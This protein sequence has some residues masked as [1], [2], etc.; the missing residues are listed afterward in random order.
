MELRASPLRDPCQPHD[1]ASSSEVLLPPATS[2]SPLPSMRFRVPDERLH[3]P[4]TV[5][6]TI[7]TPY[8]PE[9]DR[10]ERPSRC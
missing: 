9:G 10:V 6:V 4:R 2:A 3:L 8:G 7:V 5:W 1:D